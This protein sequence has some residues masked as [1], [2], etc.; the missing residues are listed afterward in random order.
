MA[1]VINWFEIPVTNIER[2]SNFYSRVLE[3]ELKQM[4]KTGIKM[5]FFINTE[6]NN[7]A[8]HSPK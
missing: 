1:N 6:G 2:A 7:I 8:F 5:A 4:E 3:G